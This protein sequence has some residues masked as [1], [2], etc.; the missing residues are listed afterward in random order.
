MANEPY[1]ERTTTEHPAGDRREEVR[2]TERRGGSATGWWI[3]ALVAVIAVAGLFFM[4]NQNSAG[5]LELQA[6]RDS[7]RADAMIESATA[8]A[9]S[10]AATA[11][12]ASSNAAASV[13]DATQAAAERSASAAEQTAR[14]AQDAAASAGDAAVDAADT[15]PER[16]N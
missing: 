8:Q 15:A 12:E 9:Q 14:S 11:S 10:A 5:E 7:G 3:A 2:V 1:V 4:Y 16:P 6:A 13:A